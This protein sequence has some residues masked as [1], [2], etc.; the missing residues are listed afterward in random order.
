MDHKVLLAILLSFWSVVLFA[1]PQQVI[2][3]SGGAFEN[4]SG[5]IS[6]T[7]GECIIGTHSS[8]GSMLTQGFQQPKLVI[9]GISPVHQNTMDIIVFPNPAGEYVILKTDHFQ[10]LSYTLCDLNGKIISRGG[11]FSTETEIDF[12]ILEPSTYLL[13]VDRNETL[14]RTFKIQKY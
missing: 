10:G 9:I 8:T 11:I 5:S 6:F 13:R 12:N 1:Q 3:S 14:I 4:S 7:I 2:S